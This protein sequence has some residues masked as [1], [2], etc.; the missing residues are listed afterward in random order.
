MSESRELNELQ[1][2]KAE[3]AKESLS[4]KDKRENLEETAKILEEKIAIQELRN[5]ND[6]TQEAIAQLEA[7]IDGLEQRL[8]EVSQSRTSEAPKFE[9]PIMPEP[10]PERIVEETVPKAEVPL[11]EPV[12]ETITVAEPEQPLTI[13]QPTY[14][15]DAKAHDKKKRKFF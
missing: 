9:T 7:K 11:E 14:D 1:E 5:G 15:D 8:K 13:Q 3:L 4:L 6:T 12:E 2:R 10:E